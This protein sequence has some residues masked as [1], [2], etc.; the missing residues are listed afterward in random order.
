LGTRL[1]RFAAVLVVG[2]LL[3]GIWNLRVGSVAVRGLC[4][5]SSDQAREVAGRLLGQRWILADTGAVA[6]ELGRLSWVEKATAHRKLFGRVEVDLQEHQPLFHCGEDPKLV[7]TCCGTVVPAPKGL[8]LNSL[9]ILNGAM[10]GDSQSREELREVLDLLHVD[11]WPF[12]RAVTEVDLEGEGG[13]ELVLEDGT[14]VWLGRHELGSRLQW[15]RADPSSW[16]REGV[17]RVDLRF[18]RQVV[19]A[20]RVARHGRSAK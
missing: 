16:R 11:P 8:A 17:G 6:R 3:V 10:E 1:L 4:L 20:S 12:E 5:S 9:P 7:V 2:S 13:V 19:L 18:D 14:E 15:L